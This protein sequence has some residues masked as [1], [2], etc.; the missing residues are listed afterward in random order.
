M[1]IG[2]FGGSFNPPHI[3]HLIVAEAVREQ[4]GLRKVW[5]MPGHTPPHK[6][7]ASLAAPRHRLAM[8]RRATAS[9][10]AFETSDLEIRRG[11]A[12]YTVETLR[13]LQER[14]P[15]TDFA[16]MVGGD[17]LGSFATWRGPEEIVRRVP[18]LAYRRPGTDAPDLPPRFARRV[19]FADAPLLDVSGTVIRAHLRRGRSIRYLVPEAVRAYIEAQGLYRAER[20]GE[21]ADVPITKPSNTER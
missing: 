8:T 6:S 7:G 16:L 1:E 15:G 9:N 2:L 17:S 14:H 10:P 3:A 19:R 13:V 11:G 4:F 20:D 12:S 18:L 21:Q 5:W